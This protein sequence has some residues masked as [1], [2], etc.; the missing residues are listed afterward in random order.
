MMPGYKASLNL[1][2]IVVVAGS[3]FSPQTALSQADSSQ[4]AQARTACASDVQRLCPNVPQG[5][6]QVLACLKQH[7]DQ[8]SNACKQAVLSATGQPGGT[9]GSTSPA[10][11][12]ASSAPAAPTPPA[13]APKAPTPSTPPP[14]AAQP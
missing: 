1:C 4:L 6:G 7:K 2:T 14:P 12:T 8:V 13:P 9:A 10:G 5:G 11:S 3:L